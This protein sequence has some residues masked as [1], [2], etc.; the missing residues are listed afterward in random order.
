MPINNVQKPLEY[1]VVSKSTRRMAIAN[2]TC[3]S[4]CNQPKAHYLATSRESRW[5]IVAGASIL[6]TSR[7]SK[8]TFWLPMG[9][10]L[11]QLR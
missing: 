3:V 5:Y 2:R 6:A 11:G 8:G 7:E 10:P 9:K 1:S 4:F